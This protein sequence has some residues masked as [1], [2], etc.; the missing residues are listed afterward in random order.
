MKV[1]WEVCPGVSQMDEI[2]RD[3][4]GEEIAFA[5]VDG[6]YSLGA[7]GDGGCYEVPDYPF[8]PESKENV[9]AAKAAAMARLEE[10]GIE[11]ELIND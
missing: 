8:D 10:R 5:A 7:C 6:S 2:L 4:N 1:R 3:E 11:L 9:Q